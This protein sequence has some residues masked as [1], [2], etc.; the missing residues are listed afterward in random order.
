MGDIVVL[1]NWVRGNAKNCFR[2]SIVYCF[3]HCLWIAGEQRHVPTCTLQSRIVA[4]RRLKIPDSEL[5]AITLEEWDKLH[6]GKR[7]S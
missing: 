7:V 4:A 3:R 1:F 2:E 5:I 6:G